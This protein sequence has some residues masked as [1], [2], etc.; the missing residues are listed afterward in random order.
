MVISTLQL[1]WHLK[2]DQVHL[3]HNKFS[4]QMQR[5]CICWWEGYA[6]ETSVLLN[7]GVWLCFSRAT[8]LRCWISHSHTL[9]AALERQGIWQDPSG[10]EGGVLWYYCQRQRSALK[11]QQ[12][13]SNC[14]HVCSWESEVQFLPSKIQLLLTHKHHPEQSSFT[15]GWSAMGA[16]CPTATGRD[17][18]ATQLPFTCC[19]HR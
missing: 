9:W 5:R 11:L 7:N 4:L 12:L 1:K 3:A 14:S 2:M 10:V 19:L 13:S 16:V 6:S 17:T 15:A 18:P 8:S